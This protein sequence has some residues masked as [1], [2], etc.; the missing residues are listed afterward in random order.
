MSGPQRPSLAGGTDCGTNAS[1]SGSNS[2]SRSSSLSKGAGDAKARWK[3][4]FGDKTVHIDSIDDGMWDNN[5]EHFLEEIARER[6]PGSS[7]NGSADGHSSSHGHSHGKLQ[8]SSSSASLSALSAGGDDSYGR[9]PRGHAPN[10]SCVGR[11]AYPPRAGGHRG[12]HS[13]RPPSATGHRPSAS[14]SGGGGNAGSSAKQRSSSLNRR[15]SISSLKGSASTGAPPQLASVFSSS[16]SQNDHGGGYK[17]RSSIDSD[18]GSIRSIRSFTSGMAPA[19]Q[20]KA[21]PTGPLPPLPPGA[22]PQAPPA[23][24]GKDKAPSSGA[25]DMSFLRFSAADIKV[26]SINSN[27]SSSSQPLSATTQATTP[28]TASSTHTNGG[29]RSSPH[30]TP[31]LATNALPILA[32][33]VRFNEHDRSLEFRPNELFETLNVDEEPES[34]RE[35]ASVASSRPFYDDRERPSSRTAT[36]A[37]SNNTASGKVNTISVNTT[38][39]SL[40]RGPLPPPPQQLHINSG[41]GSFDR[42]SSRSNACFGDG[43]YS[44]REASPIDLG[45][46]RL[47]IDDL[48][49]SFNAYKIGTP[50]S[51]PVPSALTI[52]IGHGGSVSSTEDREK[53]MNR[54]V[55]SPFAQP[56]PMQNYSLTRTPGRPLNAVP[57]GAMDIMDS[58]SV[59]TSANSEAESSN[60]VS[61]SLSER[62]REWERRDSQQ[63][64][65]DEPY[66]TDQ[67]VEKLIASGLLPH[68][69]AGGSLGSAPRYANIALSSSVPIGNLSVN[70]KEKMPSAKLGNNGLLSGL[71]RRFGASGSSTGTSLLKSSSRD[72]ALPSSSPTSQR[73]VH[74][75]VHIVGKFK[76]AS[77]M[78]AMSLAG[79]YLSSQADQG[80]RRKDAQAAGSIDDDS[81]GHLGSAGSFMPMASPAPYSA[82][83]DDYP[84][85]EQSPRSELAT[86]PLYAFEA[87]MAC[88]PLPQPSTDGLGGRKPIRALS[89]DNIHDR[90]SQ[91][92]RSYLPHHP[93]S[94]RRLGPWVRAFPV[95]AGRGAQQAATPPSDVYR[96][97][98]V[99][100][101]RSKG[102]SLDDMGKKLNIQQTTGPVAASQPAAEAPETLMPLP[103]PLLPLPP[104]AT[105]TS[106]DESQAPN[107]APSVARPTMLLDVRL[108]PSPAL[109]NQSSQAPHTP[110]TRISGHSSIVDAYMDSL[111]SP[112]MLSSST[113]DSFPLSANSMAARP[114]ESSAPSLLSESSE[115]LSPS[116]KP[117]PR[118]P[119]A[120]SREARMRPGSVQSLQMVADGVGAS[121]SSHYSARLSFGGSA[122]GTGPLSSPM[123]EANPRRPST[124]QPKRVSTSSQLQWQVGARSMGL[125]Q[126]SSPL[127]S[128]GLPP[129][130]SSLQMPCSPIGLGVVNSRPAS[131]G[132]RPLS[133]TSTSGLADSTFF[134][135][136]TLLPAANLT[137]D[138]NR[139]RSNSNPTHADLHDLTS[140]FSTPTDLPAATMQRRQSNSSESGVNGVQ[141]R[142][143]QVRR[144]RPAFGLNVAPS[145]AAAFDS[146]PSPDLT[147][148][149]ARS[150]RSPSI[151][152]FSPVRDSS[153]R[154]GPDD[155]PT[156]PGLDDVE[157]IDDDHDPV[158]VQT[159]PVDTDEDDDHELETRPLRLRHNSQLTKGFEL[160]QGQHQQQA[161]RESRDTG[162]IEL[163]RSPAKL[164]HRSS[165]A[166]LND[167]QQGRS[168]AFV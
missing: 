51:L 161:R 131:S 33:P 137:G 107:E 31:S 67:V 53:D 154:P 156:S 108:P 111:Y 20:R 56:M 116:G 43:D 112:G 57:S 40:R 24:P 26:P 153:D 16:L 28:S 45:F 138:A 102:D 52:A 9:S 61:Q 168:Y 166:S 81:A 143:P 76:P 148:S 134:A 145:A 6:G 5:D 119:K 122:S 92:A 141:A 68:G 4:L 152:V 150:P 37:A 73:K 86:V 32:S 104:T 44:S 38:P 127:L 35:N 84:R 36:R 124:A 158:T 83:H 159:I 142:Y 125:S 34:D 66:E 12:L 42:S 30:S 70:D 113:H 133:T 69:W 136:D 128:A 77:G 100:S 14:S 160:R 89:S 49:T 118:P 110:H 105:A 7:A 93:P 164:R 54:S 19:P 87:D 41:A 165:T 72:R 130:P 139:N 58:I 48:K 79:L 80:K 157:F 1:T 114:R 91:A 120:A 65:I 18:N 10:P 101:L 149:F 88:R 123:E 27:T 74:S 82:S 64:S 17:G 155:A 11:N 163:A 126:H 50:T 95:P 109:S 39:V 63:K 140:R 106:T 25:R 60:L 62:E 15:S 97:G 121:G 96:K 151:G 162:S 146:I 90:D 47:G 144:K 46:A 94:S 85:Y 21:P 13:S 3:A 2:V 22:K 135:P 78:D 99:P 147:A 167:L 55:I 71:K 59:L 75:D 8:R 132:V 115:L 98:S 117:P 23:L 29:A 129:E 103:P